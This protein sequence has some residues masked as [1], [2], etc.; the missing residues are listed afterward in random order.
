MR[1]TGVRAEPSYATARTVDR[2]SEGPRVAAL[3]ERWLGRRPT[4]WQRLVLDVGLE[5]VDGPGSPFAYDEVVVVVGRRCGKTVTAFGVP[6]AR[7]LA[8]PVHLPNGRVLPFRAIHTAQNLT[9]A[10]ERFND[11]LVEPYRR[12]FTDEQWAAAV[13]YKRAAAATTLTVDPR[14]GMDAKNVYTARLAGIAGVMR[15]LAPTASAARGAGLFHLTFDEW[16][17][18]THEQGEAL[19]SAA[20]PTLAEGFGHAQSWT[21]SNVARGTDPTTHLWHLRDKGRH[22]VKTGRNTGV[23]YVEF[24][25]PQGVDPDDEAGWWAH[26]PALGDGLVGVDQLRRDREELG[27]DSFA[28][29]YLCRWPDENELGLVGWAAIDHD[30]WAAQSTDAAMP[31]DAV[32]VL[33][34]D[35]DPFGRSSS[36]AAACAH[37]DK[38][39]TLVEIVDH[40]PG[41][42]WVGP[43]LKALMP[44]VGVVVIDSVGAGR[45]LLADLQA[46][47]TTAHK[48]VDARTADV[49]SASFMFDRDVRE[50]RLWWRTSTHHEA[51][52][53]AAAAAERTAARAW[54]WERRV[55]VSQSPLMA[56]TLASWG[57]N[58]P[59]PSEFFSF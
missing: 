55:A 17:T 49:I 4:P 26:Y 13:D 54:L 39:G 25:L 8:G 28:A 45:D 7:S 5:R 20:R 38:A 27:R 3:T 34:V 14:T 47:P 16:L 21:F 40:R 36:I 6:M 53:A 51:L 11:D 22:A 58:R 35:V 43:A 31:S 33:A 59:R 2:F 48:V 57:L 15:V 1:G 46:D 10:R 19:R 44:S 29:E 32:A 41:A 37:P 24:S 50:G 42:S 9:A 23:C 12:S 52:T 56:A 18:F 30:R